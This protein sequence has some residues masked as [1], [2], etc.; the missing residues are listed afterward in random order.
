MVY[1]VRPSDSMAKIAAAHEVT[2]GALVRANPQIE[3]PALIFPGQQI[4]IPR[5]VAAGET[6][7]PAFTG[8]YRVRSGDTMRKI[9][10]AFRVPL[11]QLVAANSQI[12]NPDIIRVGEVINVPPTAPTDTVQRVT[13]PSSGSGPAWYRT[14]KREMD[15][16]IVE[17][18][19]RDH[20]P[21]ILEYHASVT[22]GF[23][24]NEVPWC[25]SFV[26]WCM[27]QSDIRGTDSA[28]A[29]SW[30]RWGKKLATPE[31]GAI[32]VFWRESK[33]SRKGHVGFYVKETSTHISVLGGNQGNKV[34]VDPYP[35][36]R[37]LSYRWPKG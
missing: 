1:I 12:A 22:G 6:A 5:T 28:G 36:A 32:T 10:R 9:A 35:K 13:T 16:G 27:E 7:S 18:P 34:T 31:L 11:A 29:R 17:F 25:S 4:N 15:D 19:G 8:R 26:N 2:L 30:E 3:D 14:A 24:E 37:L 20:N 21:R 33:T 23:D